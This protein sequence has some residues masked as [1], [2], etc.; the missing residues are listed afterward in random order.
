MRGVLT[1]SALLLTGVT[2]ALAGCSVLEPKPDTSR[3]FLLRSVVSEAGQAPLD[4]LVLGLGPVAVPDYL[5]RAEMLDLVGPYELRY[6]PDNRW[7]EP[8]GEQ[9]RRT[10][11]HNLRSLLRPDAVVDYPWSLTDGVSLEVDVTFDAIR[12]DES[13]AW[14]GRVEWV[15]RAATTATALERSALEFELGRDAVPPE[16]VARGLSEELGRLAEDIAA[17]VR[18]HHPVR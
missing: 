15:L 12:L 5:D 1:R 14:R 3:Y 2:A 16:D 13:G 11:A 18:R 6:S 10:L 9:L 4:D 17:G 7:V 8:L